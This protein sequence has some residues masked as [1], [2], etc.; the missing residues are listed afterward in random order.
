MTFGVVYMLYT[1]VGVPSS[2][3]KLG[4]FVYLYTLFAAI[5]GRLFLGRKI[6]REQHRLIA[7]S[8]VFLLALQVLLGIYSFVL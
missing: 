7:I 1:I 4:L 2:H 8:A 6:K 5:S 3:G